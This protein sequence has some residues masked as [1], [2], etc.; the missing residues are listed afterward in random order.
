MGLCLF[1]RSTLVV[2][3]AGYGGVS[4]IRHVRLVIVTGFPH[5]ILVPVKGLLC[6][7]QG[8]M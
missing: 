8:V 3:G 5:R 4:T 7:L 1:A 6:R 2:G